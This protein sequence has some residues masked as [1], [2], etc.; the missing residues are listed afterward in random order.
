VLGQRYEIWHAMDGKRALELLVAQRHDLVLSDVM[1][2]GMSGLELCQ[3]IKTDPRIQDTPVI[4]LTA[5]EGEQGRIE[6]HWVGADVY[7]TKPF[8]PAELRAAIEAQLSGR[9]RRSESASHRRAASLET[10]LAGL[11]HELRNACHQARSAQTVLLEMHRKASEG[12][13][14]TDKPGNIEEMHAISLRAL[15]RIAAVVQSLQQYAVQRMR[16]PWSDVDLDEII[17]TEVSHLVMIDSERIVLDLS[18][19]AGAIV[20]GPREELRQL[21]LNLI[22]NAVK[23]VG[24]GGTIRV[25]TRIET[26]MVRLE[27]EDDGCGIAADNRERVF[28]LFFTSREPGQGVGL[29]L[30]L[31]KKTVEDLRGSIE[32]TSEPGHGA[33]FTVRLPR[34]VAVGELAATDAAAY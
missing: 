33:R 21:V 5:K 14:A 27:V 4:L 32:V 31:V 10:L 29:G 28:D 20:R 12:M 34:Q 7:L 25:S 3:R 6:G 24:S 30:A 13:P 17:R 22:E 26:G 11:A 19:E 23:A 16:L 2:P 15:D 18:L 1:M 9:Q 8:K